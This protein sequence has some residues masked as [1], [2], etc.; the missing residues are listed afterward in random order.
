MV[1]KII[2]I[3]FYVIFVQS[4]LYSQPTTQTKDLL[5]LT[6]TVPPPPTAAQLGLYG[7]CPVS[8]YVGRPEIHIPLYGID[9]DNYNFPIELNYNATGNKVADVSSWIGLGWSLNAG[10]IITRTIRGVRDEIVY[11]GYTSTAGQYLNDSLLY[12]PITQQNYWKFDALMDISSGLIDGQP[13]QYYFNFGKYCGSFIFDQNK[14]IHQSP[15]NRQVIISC[16]RAGITE[17]GHPDTII[18]F[19]ITTEDGAQYLFGNKFKDKTYFEKFNIRSQP[20]IPFENPNIGNPGYPATMYTGRQAEQYKLDEYINSWYLYQ[21]ILPNLLDTI[22]FK[23]E[24]DS[25]CNYSNWNDRYFYDYPDSQY[26]GEQYWNEIIRSWSIYYNVVERLT[27]INWRGGK[28]S[29]IKNPVERKDVD[30]DTNAARSSGYALGKIEIYNNK[31][32]KL[33]DINFSTSYF[34]SNNAYNNEPKD[35]PGFYRRLKLDSITIGIDKYEFTYDLQEMPGRF[36]HLTDFWDYYK[37]FNCC[38]SNQ[39]CFN[40]NYSC[41]LKTSNPKIYCYPHDTA[42]PVYPGIYSIYPRRH[43]YDTVYVLDGADRYPDSIYTQANILKSIKYPTGGTDSF[44]YEL[45]SFIIDSTERK[46]GGLRIKRILTY[47][48]FSHKNDI[49]KKYEYSLFNDST[50]TSGQFFSIPECA[51]YNVYAYDRAATGKTHSERWNRLTTRFSLSQSSLNGTKGNQIGYSNVT[52]QTVG[53]K[54]TSQKNGKIQYTFLVSGQYGVNHDLCGKCNY[55]IDCIY[56]KTNKNITVLDELVNNYPGA[57]PYNLK[58][59]DNFPFLLN[60]NMD[61]Y[62]GLLSNETKMNQNGDTVSSIL[63]QYCFDTLLTKT[64]EIKAAYYNA[65]EQAFRIIQCD[66]NESCINSFSALYH[67]YDIR[68]GINYSISNNICLTKKTEKNYSLNDPLKKTTTI[69]EYQYNKLLQLHKIL[70]TNSDGTTIST[71]YKYPSDYSSTSSTYDDYARG[72]IKMKTVNCI[73]RPIETFKSV[74]NNSNESVTEGELNF[75]KV[76]NNDRFYL[77]KKQI[78]ETNSGLSSFSPSR[79][80]NSGDFLFN[81]YYSDKYFFDLYDTYQ[82]IEQTHKKDDNNISYFWDPNSLYPIIKGE[83]I[84]YSDLSSAVNSSTNNLAALINQIGDM[85][86]DN[87]KYAWRVFNTTLRLQYNV[88]NSFLTTFTYKPLV[89]TTSITDPNGISTYYEYDNYG[90]LIIIRDNDNNIVKQFD[91]HYSQQ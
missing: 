89:G 21:I 30:K 39:C 52:V 1:K 23:Y 61:Y 24:S 12:L 84:I 91:Y 19:Q 44:E 74:T 34:R 90:R 46:A 5:D 87:Q 9:L 11:N 57:G 40:S 26:S 18:S 6:K 29:F 32:E 69:T 79:I 62:N 45:N 27:E 86:T 68:W 31:M 2:V 25:I 15:N 3:T 78:L 66:E 41:W 54:T 76:D 36:S 81:N 82:N 58:D 16:Q 80:S 50:K 35:C 73:N 4:F 17:N 14:Q 56:Y 33:K 13:D 85:L 48:G 83:N 59:I 20:I 53:N 70:F 64:Y 72:I 88:R 28:L 43:Y 38:N 49:I 47:D 22:K 7:Q 55:D 8:L 65:I 60:P 77:F 51:Q 63:Y 42:N 10:G 37:N 75:F 71:T 67:L